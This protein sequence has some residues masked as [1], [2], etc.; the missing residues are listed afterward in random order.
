MQH[1]FHLLLQGHCGALG[2]AAAGAGAAGLG[3]A[4]LHHHHQG[5]EGYGQQGVTTRAGRAM[6]S[7]ECWPAG[8]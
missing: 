6:A 7:R 2:G 1:M 4:A 5:G 8:L 3:G